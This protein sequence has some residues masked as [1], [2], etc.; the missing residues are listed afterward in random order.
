MQICEG[1]VVF[2]C[3]NTDIEN[4]LVPCLQLVLQKG[5]SVLSVLGLIS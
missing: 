3:L 1:G 2:G 4:P 5:M